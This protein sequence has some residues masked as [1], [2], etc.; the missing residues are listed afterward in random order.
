MRQTALCREV[1]TAKQHESYHKDFNQIQRNSQISFLKRQNTA[2]RRERDE[3]ARQQEEE[4]KEAIRQRQLQEEQELAMQLHDA[5]RR[6]INE[7]KLRQQLRESNQ[8]LR[9]LETKLRAA[10]VAKGIAAQKAE[11]EARRLEEKI[12][13]QKEQEVLEQQRLD[14]LEYIKQCEEEQWKQK[15]ELRDTLHTQMKA[16]QRQKQI[17]Y[18]E[19]LREKQYLDEICK[20]LQ[21]ERFAEIQRKLEL[22]KRTRMEMEYFKEAKAI[23][24]ERQKLALAE[25]NE[26]IR[27][28]LEYRDAQERELRERKVECTRFREQLN[29]KMVTE[30]QVEI[31]SMVANRWWLGKR[32]RV[33]RRSRFRNLATIS[34]QVSKSF[35]FYMDVT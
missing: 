17:M 6:R 10:Y 15:C 34:I 13:A 2:Q 16:L 32:N 19:F 12:A 27:R 22:Q 4:A 21:E 28:F 33:G 25:E 7:E 31:V 3:N 23:W 9:E 1:E 18:E 35:L 14:N 30:L 11:L 24:Q 26:R 29:E 8:E 20:R 5:N